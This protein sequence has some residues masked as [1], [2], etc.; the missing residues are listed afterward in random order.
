LDKNYQNKPTD[1]YISG[2]GLRFEDRELDL[3]CGRLVFLS[4][5]SQKKRKKKKNCKGAKA[6][7]LRKGENKA[8]GGG[9][10]VPRNSRVYVKPPIQAHMLATL[11]ITLSS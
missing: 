5:N 7:S 11:C 3:W 1:D 8:R 4:V 9:S 2:Y 10:F 6:P